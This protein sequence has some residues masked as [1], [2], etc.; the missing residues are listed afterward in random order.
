M[1]APAVDVADVFKVHTTP[2][3][4]SSAALQGLALRV[5]DGEIVTVLGPSGSGKTSL[6]R[7]LAG[8]DRP[9]T[10]KAVVYGL[11]L[12]RAS[13]RRLSSYRASTV[14]YID[15]HYA[16]A[17]T[18]ELSAVNAVELPLALRGIAPSTRRDRAHELLERVGLEHKA[19]GRPAELSGGEQQR[20]AICAALAA[21]PRLVLADEPTGEL[22]S[23]SAALVYGVLRELVREQ[24]STLVL[25]SHDPASTAFADRTIRIRD[26]RVS[27]EAA[28]ADGGDEVLVVGR[29][30][31]VRVPEPLLRGAGIASHAR[32][33]A[34]NG[35]VVLTP[36]SGEPAQESP[37]ARSVRRSSVPAA[38]EVSLLDVVMEYG[39]GET[40]TRVLDGLTTDF[41]PRR[42]HAVTGP[43]GSGKTTLLN[44]IAGLE[45]PTSG[46]I[47]VLGEP[48]SGLDR[49]DRARLRRDRVAV[50]SQQLSLPPFLTV[51][52]T[53]DLGLAL[54]GRRSAGVDEAIAAVGL[55]ERAQHRVAAL[56]AGEQV[57]VAIARA[58][59]A[60]SPVLLADEPTARLDQANSLLLAELLRA[61]AESGLIVICATHDPLL[62]EHAHRELALAPLGA[63]P[64][65]ARSEHRLESG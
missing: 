47:V 24:A 29:G 49:E 18:P 19:G 64:R 33:S 31:W 55:A 52:E 30:G 39:V 4:A 16:L 54:R 9:S 60:E 59:A 37:A 62:I 41:A 40:A 58:I 10:G 51:R 63:E 44:L 38:G 46:E 8:F 2:E 12:G 50:V 14:G 26:G 13:R 7:I 35:R 57:R 22:D 65:P 1:S 48:L 28:S 53:V 20:V 45:A 27:E 34:E 21:R 11:D 3:G 61:L 42:Y 36:T 56:S 25:V 6:L 15:Q 17:L 23:D 43:S 5:D 32:A